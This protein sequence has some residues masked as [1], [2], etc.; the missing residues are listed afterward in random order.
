MGFT[1]GSAP[2]AIELGQ[3]GG[4]VAEALCQELIQGGAADTIVLDLFQRLVG[5]PPRTLV[6]LSQRDLLQQQ[7][8]LVR[9]GRLGQSPGRGV[10]TGRQVGLNLFAQGRLGRGQASPGQAGP[11]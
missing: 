8:P 10:F 11:S 4:G 2:A 6:V 9:G 3:N 7:F 5:R 1:H